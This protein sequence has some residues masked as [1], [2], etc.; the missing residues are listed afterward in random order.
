MQILP[1]WKW[2]KLFLSQIIRLDARNHGN[3]P[4]SEDMSYEA[5]SYDV[6]KVMDN[7]KIEKACLMGHSMGGKAFMT[8]ALLHVRHTS[9][10]FISII[11]LLRYMYHQTS[12][13]LKH[14]KCIYM[15]Q[16]QDHNVWYLICT[17]G[18]PIRICYS[19]AQDG[20]FRYFLHAFKYWD[21][22]IIR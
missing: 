16:K 13:F 15:C 4:H 10:I 19:K 7:M 5:M 12:M 22:D 9:F 8:T 14:Y 18:I 11:F 21:R 20:I 2:N 6:L 17:T 1:H 3:S